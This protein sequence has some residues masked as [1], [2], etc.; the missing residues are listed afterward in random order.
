LEDA[1]NFIATR[2]PDE[3]REFIVPKLDEMVDQAD[4]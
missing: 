3:A 1:R 4:R 2:L